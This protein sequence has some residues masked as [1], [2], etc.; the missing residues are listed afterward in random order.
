M[1]TSVPQMPDPTVPQQPALS[2]VERIVDTFVTP[3]KTFADI[4]RSAAWW[5]PFVLMILISYGFSFTLQ[6]RVGWS[7]AT[8]NIMRADPGASARM[9]KLAPDQQQRQMQMITKSTSI[10]SY[11]Y[12]LLIVVIALIV[13]GVMML[14]CNMGVGGT[15]SYG[16]YLAVWFYAS[17]IQSLKALLTILVMFIGD[18]DNFNIK[19]PIGSNLGYYFSPGSVPAWLASLLTSLDIFTIWTM[20]VMSIGFSIVGR[21]SRSAATGVVFGW[22]ALVVLCG[23]GWAAIFG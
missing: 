19:N 16:Q 9:E 8:E 18:P 13:A 12:P 23:V 6:K 3:S 1:A 22:W 4:R 7:R 2:Q 21:I 14:T 20:I 10:I 11:C 17:L 15:G 5:M